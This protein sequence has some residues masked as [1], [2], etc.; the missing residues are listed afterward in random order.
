[1]LALLLSAANIDSQAH[2]V[3]RATVYQGEARSMPAYLVASPQLWDSWKDDLAYGYRRKIVLHDFETI[4]SSEDSRPKLS[5][6][7]IFARKKDAHI[8]MR[9]MPGAGSWSAVAKVIRTPASYYAY[10][11]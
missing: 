5:R 10:R 6:S 3:V 9:G 8:F 7:D 2:S 11:P 1:M 4:N